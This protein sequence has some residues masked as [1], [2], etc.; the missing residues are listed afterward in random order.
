[1]VSLF[2]P[3]K[4]ES[5]K[6]NA[7]LSSGPTT[8]EDLVIVDEKLR[9]KVL[10][11]A[12][13]EAHSPAPLT[14]PLSDTPQVDEAVNGAAIAIEDARKE[15][16]ILNTGFEREK[17]RLLL[18]TKDATIIQEGSVSYRRVT[19]LRKMFLE[20]HIILLNYKEDDREAPVLRLFDNVWLYT[21]NSSS[22]WKLSYDAYHLAEAQLVFSGGFRADVIVAED[23]FEAGLAGW[24]LSEKYG[25]P[26]Q[27]HL[28]EDFYDPAFIDMQDHPILY[29]WSVR[30]LLERV[31]SV[32][33]KTEFQRHAVIIENADLE[34][35][36][37]LLPSYYNLEAWRDFV[38]TFNLREKYPQFK[39]IILHVSSM[40]ANSHSKE[41]LFG[42][43]KLLR[44]YPTI[45]L[46]MVGNGPLRPMLERHAIALGLQKQIEFE[47]T[48]PE[49]L[50]YMKSAHILLH[51]SEDG[52]E[53]EVILEA[54]VAKLPMIANVSGLAGKLF[55]D[56]ESA[57]LCAPNDVAC[58]A[59]N[60]NR[61]LNENQDRSRFALNASEIVFERIE[62]DY[63]AYL[64]SY[65]SSIER[66]I[67]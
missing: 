23:L 13:A 26:L 47:P 5:D 18:I 21:T 56:G 55:I 64:E 37:E 20:I 2:D 17:V 32:R 65:R 50:S 34:S 39:F 66:C 28:Y 7:A 58:V 29:G 8:E 53:D 22:W 54:A 67:V 24:F 33:T 48:P 9:D 31:E 36:T 43:A 59:D 27:L 51:L 3:S 16:P 10:Q 62:Q 44:R 6:L 15:A 12:A 4:Q 63:S 46:I 60:I 57:C 41:A 42:A 19:D 25:R 11:E 49:V 52:S 1:M 35:R 30:Y 61:Y 45:G 40:R 38:P 14:T